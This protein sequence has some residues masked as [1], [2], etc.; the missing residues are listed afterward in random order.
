MRCSFN[1]GLVRLNLGFFLAASSYAGA[2]EIPITSPHDGKVPF[3]VVD[4]GN[5]KRS[6]GI[7]AAA[8]DG[9]WTPIASGKVLKGR[10][11]HGVIEQFGLTKYSKRYESLAVVNGLLHL[12]YLPSKRFKPIVIGSESFS[13]VDAITG[14][15]IKLPRI[16]SHGDIN[17]YA[18]MPQQGRE[19]VLVSVKFPDGS[20]FDGV[21]FFFMLDANETTEEP[22]FIRPPTVLD[23]RFR[24]PGELA[25]LVKAKGL[26]S[27]IVAKS[28]SKQR[29]EDTQ[30]LTEW[31][32]GLVSSDPIDD[33]LDMPLIDPKEGTLR[34]EVLPSEVLGRSGFFRQVYDP[35]SGRDY[36]EISEVGKRPGRLA[37]IEGEAAFL[38]V[39]SESRSAE[40]FLF[41]LN[42][43]LLFYSQGLTI[44]IIED[45][46]LVR[47]DAFLV[48]RGN[49]AGLIIS[50]DDPLGMTEYVELVFGEDSSASRI[51]K[52]FPI[53]E[54]FINRDE[55]VARL[56]FLKDELPLFDNITPGGSSTADYEAQKIDTIPYLDLA[57]SK[58]D[59]LQQRYLRPLSEVSLSPNVKHY[60]FDNTHA[61]QHQTGVFN[62]NCRKSDS[63]LLVGE[64]LSYQSAN[65]NTKNVL[66]AY[67][68]SAN[69]GETFVITLAAVDPAFNQGQ[70]GFS[71]VVIVDFV[72][73][74]G[75]ETQH[76]MVRKV[77]FEVPF[78]SLK[79]VRIFSG[80]KD[81][82]DQHFIMASFDGDR[83]TGVQLVK[84]EI[85]KNKNGGF[86]A[87][88]GNL[89]PSQLS[90][91]YIPDEVID[92][93]L[94]FSREGQPYFVDTPHLGESDPDFRITSLVS[95]KS[96]NPQSY[97]G[98]LSKLI[99]F[100][101][102]KSELGDTSGDWYSRSGLRATWQAYSKH[103]IVEK[104]QE[105]YQDR[106][107]IDEI[108]DEI[109]A[110]W[111]VFDGLAA[112]LD[113]L[114]SPVSTP[115][116]Q[117]FIV[118]D[119]TKI[120]FINYALDLLGSNKA[121]NWNAGYRSGGEVKFF[122]FDARRSNQ[123]EVIEN[124][125]HAGKVSSPDVP[126]LIV[127]G[128]QLINAQMNHKINYDDERFFHLEHAGDY[129]DPHLLY[130]ILSQGNKIALDGFEDYDFSKNRLRT[131]IIAS[132]SEWKRI[133]ESMR[134]LRQN[135][136]LKRVTENRSFLN[137]N[138]RI[139]PPDVSFAKDE[140]VKL[141]AK[142]RAQAE[143]KLIPNL[144][145]EV[146]ELA[147]QA[148]RP[149]HKVFLI[150][151]ELKPFVRKLLLS[152]WANRASESKADPIWG[153][154]NPDLWLFDFEP[155]DGDSGFEQQVLMN[156]LD[157]IRRVETKRSVLMVDMN[158]VLSQATRLYVDEKSKKF[159]IFDPADPEG[160]G[161]IPHLF[162]TIAS[163]G[164][165]LTAEK[166]AEQQKAI[167]IICMGTPSEWEALRS[168]LD[169]EQRFGLLD[170][171]EVVKLDE[172]DF[173]TKVNL[174]EEVFHRPQIEALNYN[175]AIDGHEDESESVRRRKLLSFTVS[176]ISGQAIQSRQDPTSAYL[177]V[178]NELSEAVVKDP[179]VRNSGVIDVKFVERIMAKVFNTA[180]SPNILPPDDPLIKLS[181]P[182]KA[183]LA[184]Q[185]AGYEGPLDLK[186]RF[187]QAI[188]SQTKVNTVRPIPASIVIYGEGS[189]GKTVLIKSLVDMVG[190][191][192]YDFGT[193]NN[194]GAQAMILNCQ[195]IG[196][197]SKINPESMTV[198]EAIQHINNLL[199]LPNG[200]RSFILLDDLHKTPPEDLRK[201][202]SYLQALFEVNDGFARVNDRNGSIH[203]VPVKNLT[204]MMTL[205][206]THEPDKLK[207]FAPNGTDEEIIAASLS[208]DD[209]RVDLSFI[210]RWSYFFN[211]NKFPLEAK[212]PGLVDSLAEA[213]VGEFN[214]GGNL[215]IVSID[216]IRH[217]VEK[218]PDANAREFL[219]EATS[220]ILGL[221]SHQV[222]GSTAYI[223]VPRRFSN[224]SRDFEF[225]AEGREGDDIARTVD[226][227]LVAVPVGEGL[228]G[229][230]AL[231][232]VMVDSFR[233]LAFDAFINA[234]SQDQRFLAKNNAAELVY[235]PFLTSISA[236]L[237]ARL[238]TQA[239][240]LDPHQFGISGA[241]SIQRFQSILQDIN[242]GREPYFPFAFADEISNSQRLHR[243]IDSSSFSETEQSRLDVVTATSKEF[244]AVMRE[245]LAEMLRVD[246]LS[247][248]PDSKQWIESLNDSEP[249]AAITK[250]GKE[251]V[252][253][254]LRMTLELD[255]PHLTENRSGDYKPSTFENGRLFT[256][257]MDRAIT[258]MPWGDVVMFM[259]GNM[260]VMARNLDLSR[261]VG[262]QHYL[263][264]SRN[265]LLRPSTSEV[266][267]QTLSSIRAFGKVDPDQVAKLESGF[268]DSC[269]KI[270]GRP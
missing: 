50:Y 22:Y 251:M 101:K 42:N 207:R 1:N 68:Y 262:L 115:Q 46:N 130:L 139:W 174:L 179:S 45:F 223:I 56:E 9:A 62:H 141:R 170:T 69:T 41:V 58:M 23:Y 239:L 36:V 93:R 82:Q 245:F 185:K 167:S 228:E 133:Q 263:F 265:S 162:Y 60:S 77:N 76:S 255:Q 268:L 15:P 206:P 30:V 146:A 183:A 151:Q 201:L 47:F 191:K 98:D 219:S 72:D 211:I 246:S 169:F 232:D 144:F 110:R 226:S 180:L 26:Y 148:K 80:L 244:E 35:I 51:E 20:Q 249:R 13:P 217:V 70:R 14:Q 91:E 142:K 143:D 97:G 120:D 116:T 236:G 10:A 100:G 126:L 105:S 267:L 132:E 131:M 81:H 238:P 221:P 55:I 6:D 168:S 87:D 216:A 212:A 137:L 213:A 43:D 103:G 177:K 261:K 237:S 4:G 92:V 161:Q 90:K 18:N 39:S 79:S 204:L 40:G 150:S 233:I 257:A 248:L 198:E 71:L 254:Y 108:T 260:N 107:V 89:K 220:K 29:G 227:D 109:R 21:S 210:K 99:S 32:E 88:F 184:L 53:L 38:E 59:N 258:R 256:Y 230:L 209:Y 16:A 12:I 175:F 160:H 96:V 194:Q 64:L 33:S 48:Q 149:K 264:N 202:M 111:H 188:L 124:L 173:E 145:S 73:A 242:G 84:V 197:D 65:G 66:N 61:I 259:L 75:H 147:D 187:V 156:Q 153:Y 5:E 214:V 63:E 25:T 122:V 190:L 78:E 67:Q 243:F 140:I 195:R 154:E 182:I 135:F 218:Y 240:H 31:R 200:H 234:L 253:L 224:G 225:G 199:S 49:T 205:N 52:R 158:D 117:A 222:G 164:Q 178:Y 7:Y 193:E 112:D 208:T 2:S 159:E 119:D 235:A 171:F 27:E 24:S 166:I 114:A 123:F 186:R 241:A 86:F 102:I 57:R 152:K 250:L 163:E 157:S 19:T 37:R 83:Q 28:L 196:T 127:D 85:S 136:A 106:I 266:S 104:F 231:L 165:T 54:R 203:E 121:P 125:Q 8:E 128:A 172:P 118:S 94:V 192:L 155:P 247:E 74:S 176:R 134:D 138:W 129:I 229:R 34:L 270:F 252:E 113:K 181:D 95:N 44:K 189:T 17:V 269:S 11:N 215:V 3:I